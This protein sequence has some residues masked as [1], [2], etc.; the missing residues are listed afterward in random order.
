MRPLLIAAILI[1]AAA[2]PLSAASAGAAGPAPRV[3]TVATAHLDTQWRWTIRTTIDE[4][5]KAT[6]DDN[7][8]L[9][10]RYPDYVFNFEGAFRY[11]LAEEY[12]PARFARLQEYVRQGRW[13]VCGSW[14]DA[15]DVNMPAPESL[16]RHALYGNGWFARELG[17]RSV[18]VFLPDCFGFGYALPSIMAHSGLTGFSTQKLTWG[19][20]YGTPFDV[21]RWRGVDGSTVMAAVNPGSYSAGFAVDLSRDSTVAAAI[22]RTVAAGGPPVAFKYYGTGDT[23]GAPDETSVQWLERSVRS[24]GPVQVISAGADQIFRE[25][26]PDQAASL[27]VYDGELV[28]TRHGTGCYTSEA[29]MKRWFRRCEVLADAAERAAAL[30]WWLG[31]ADYPAATLE[32]AWT[33]FLW[34]AFHDDLTGTSIPEAYHFSW[35]DLLLSQQ[36]FAQVLTAS[37]AGIASG[38]D[39]EVDG[40]PLLVFNPLAFERT[41]TVTVTL[42]ARDLGADVQV[43]GPDGTAMPAQA[44]RDGDDL[45]LSFTA[46]A[47]A[48]GVAVFTVRAGT[49]AADRAPV[50]DAATGTLTSLHYRLRLTAQ[51]LVS[52]VDNETGRELLAAPPRLE[53]LH[54]SPARWPAW[55]IDYDDIT[56]APYATVPLGGVPGTVEIG[57]AL[58]RFTFVH[59]AAGS[60]FRQTLTVADER[61][62]W[63]LDIDWAS[64]GTLLKAAFVTTAA[65]TAATYDLG[66]GAIRRGVDRPGLYEVPGQRWADLTDPSGAFGL[67]V[68][69][70]GRYGWDHPDPATLRLSLLRTPAVDDQWTWVADEASQDLGHHRVTV[71]LRGHG[72]DWR[73]AAV[74]AADALNQP[75]VVFATDRHPG[76]RGRSVSL[77]AV[78]DPRVAVRA[79][80]KSEEGDRLV[81]RLQEVTG[82]PATGVTVRAAGPITGAIDLLADERPVSAPSHVAVADGRLTCS[83]GPYRPR[84]LALTLASPAADRRGATRPRTTL[85]LPWNLDGIATAAAP[86]DGDLDG[87][88][89]R[90]P[91]ACVPA[92]I[93]RDGV[94]FLTGPQEP[95]AANLV[96]CAGQKLALPERGP[97]ELQLLV[98]ALG[99]PREA[100]FTV[101]DGAEVRAWIPDGR[102]FFGQG[103]DRI[104]GED[105]AAEA[106]DVVPAYVTD[107]DLGWVVTH[108]LDRDGAPESYTYTHFYRV[109]IPVGKDARSITLPDDP[110]IVVLAAT[111]VDAR[112]AV[113]ALTPL[114]DRPTRPSLRIDAVRH[115]FVDTLCFRL[116]SP[117]RGAVIRW[118]RRGGDLARYDGRPIRLTDSADLVFTA[119]AP[120]Y[121]D[122]VTRAASFTRLDPWPAP[123]SAGSGAPGLAA[124]GYEGAWNVLPD[125]SVL[126]PILE[127]TTPIVT[128]PPALRDEDIG[129]VLTGAIDVPARGM[130]R[131]WLSSDDGSRMW[132]DG[133]PLID[134]DGLHGASPVKADA[135]LEGG[136]HVLR[137]EFFQHLGGRELTLEWS[138]PGFARQ[139]VPAS[140]LSH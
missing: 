20:A 24:D 87:A 88:G 131:F 62:D 85:R 12:Y 56:A 79:V 1:A 29:A 77:L 7:F 37:V 76:P 72:A 57:P 119:S 19:S 5:L 66:L 93:E 128:I 52:L 21:G 130:Y 121:G 32:R 80:K 4:Y 129:A 81:V 33:R 118:G 117:N 58:A 134:A 48:C 69:N 122:A 15:V 133:R 65:D 34:H 99:A 83:L 115:T 54:D 111:E 140:A 16:F 71:S 98:C 22:G 36:A 51:G 100:A 138:G 75:L 13:R 106:A 31:D 43:L 73:P 90:L 126:V 38:M 44:T 70:D 27:P 40:R 107:A 64:K 124:S 139:P 2:A 103:D 26:T 97:Q 10:E 105:L 47:P 39:T 50:W 6:L 74:R 61:L 125:W 55:E 92:T 104:Q 67:T 120:G 109:T 114:V 45:R 102:A 91:G 18:D 9:L 137:I 49:S 60:T 123:A 135:P 132:L 46:T 11:Q 108:R 95:G 17:V 116:S 23:G 94:R 25:L 68:L 82:E 59:E 96:R 112:P 127:T 136:R 30:A 113:R 28:M 53:L 41:G 86:T 78:E 3:Y 89:H 8:A 63:D 101:S 14:L 35:N 84:T 42:P 110:A